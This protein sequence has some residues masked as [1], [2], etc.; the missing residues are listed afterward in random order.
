MGTPRQAMGLE[1]VEEVIGSEDNSSGRGR[2][3]FR[4]YRGRRG[5][6]KGTKHSEISVENELSNAVPSPSCPVTVPI[7]TTRA[8][9]YN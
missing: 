5:K 3:T 6:Q 8:A 4:W 9:A 2:D 7:F 1:T